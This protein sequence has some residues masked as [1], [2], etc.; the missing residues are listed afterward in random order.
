MGEKRMIFIGMCI[1]LLMGLTGSGVQARSNYP[2]LDKVSTNSGSWYVSQS[3]SDENSCASPGD[4]CLTIMVAVSK[5][6]EGE[7]VYVSS[8]TYIMGAGYYNNFI[9][10]GLTLSGGWNDTFTLQDGFSTYNGEGGEICLR[11]ISTVNATISHF[12]FQNCLEA[13][14]AAIVNEGKLTIQDSIIQNASAFGI[15]NTGDVLIIRTLIKDINIEY[16]GGGIYNQ[17]GT[18]TLIDSAVIH[19]KG[20]LGGGINNQDAQ[21][22]MVNS[23]ISNNTG[24]KV[25][26][27]Y[28]SGSSTINIYNGSITNNHG[29]EQSGGIDVLD[30]GV[31]TIHNSILA[32]NWQG[33]DLQSPS[34]C[35]GTITSGGYNLVRTTTGCNFVPSIGDLTNISPGGILL[36]NC[37]AILPTSQ[38]IDA[39]N[40]SGCLDNLGNPIVDD[41]R[42]WT[43]PM[44]GNNDGISVC[45]IGAYELNPAY[46]PRLSF[47]TLISKACQILYQDDFSNPDSGWPI[48]DSG[49]T[50]VGY[51]NGEYQILIRTAG[52]LNAVS[53]G[54]G[55]QDY[56]VSVQL[57]N[58]TG[59]F[60]SYG[61]IFG[62]MPDWSSWY[63]LEIYPDGWYGVYKYDTY[64]GGKVFAEAF[65]PA[66]KLST[67]TNIITVERNTPAITVYANGQIL[68]TIPS[69]YFYGS[70]YLGLINYSY[71]Q[72]NIDVRFDNFRVVP[73]DCNEK[74]SN[75]ELPIPLTL[76][77]FEVNQYSIENF[78][79]FTKHSP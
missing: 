11:N 34:D 18:L 36:N 1:V 6:A 47:M 43:R 19:N 22:V 42:G 61:I 72:P 63:S 2:D 55:T 37:Y 54:F 30:T 49:N 12:V 58:V 64:G 7:T 21:F 32:D 73:V 70:R 16:F 25:G 68:T 17:E 56:K 10:K 76:H 65:S 57:R 31:V 26:G 41:Q 69:E 48:N 29:S 66:I 8:G 23:T 46:P 62:I 33:E 78:I 79:N 53:S 51:I 60:A 44:D 39:G 28:S 74:I 40:P 50:K 67:A 13:S 27:I 52:W 3:G 38:A 35:Q 5:A 14:E 75:R 77:G 15:K 24:I 71:D 9:N 45:D 20:Y 4:A 59:A